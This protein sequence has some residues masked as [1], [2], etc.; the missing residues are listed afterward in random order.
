MPCQVDPSGAPPEPK[1][2]K[3]RTCTPVKPRR[4]SKARR[5]A[6]FKWPYEQAWVGVL[7]LDGKAEVIVP[8]ESSSDSGEESPVV[9]PRL[10]PK[11]TAREDSD[12]KDTTTDRKDQPQQQVVVVVAKPAAFNRPVVLPLA[13]PVQQL[14]LRSSPAPTFSIPEVA[15]PPRPQGMCDPYARPTIDSLD[16]CT[17]MLS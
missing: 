15:A 11:D 1:K 17:G 4:K 10:R 16:V 12:Q 7:N 5:D 6:A 13:S 2:R 8:D 14:Q 3:P 9:R